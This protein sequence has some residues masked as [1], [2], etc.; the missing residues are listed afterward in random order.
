MKGSMHTAGCSSASCGST[1]NIGGLSPSELVSKFEDAI[2]K[3]KSSSQCECEQPKQEQ[4]KSLIQDADVNG[5]KKLSASELASA[6]DISLDDAKE[7]VKEFNK[8]CD[9]DSALDAKELTKGLDELKKAAGKDSTDKPEDSACDKKPA[10]CGD[11][12][13][14]D[15]CEESAGGNLKD[16]LS[17]IMDKDGDGKVSPEEMKCFIEKHDKNGDG[18]LDKC[19]LKQALKAEDPGLTKMPDGKLDK[20]IKQV[21]DDKSKGID[22]IELMYAINQ[23]SGSEM[24]VS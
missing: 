21:D 13:K 19:E 8:P 5:D 9:K 2:H 1:S 4:I 24:N 23:K 16:V 12:K 14:S 3:T 7:L 6:L 11:E 20:L 15:S 10:K 17:K 18:E 22:G